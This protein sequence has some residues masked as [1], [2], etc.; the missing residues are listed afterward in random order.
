MIQDQQR[1]GYSVKTKSN[2]WRARSLLE[3]PWLFFAWLN[4]ALEPGDA[5]C[6]TPGGKNRTASLGNETVKA[7]LSEAQAG[8]M[9][10]LDFE[11][12][13]GLLRPNEASDA[14]TMRGRLWH[15]YMK[16]DANARMGAVTMGEY[17]SSFYKNGWISSETARRYTERCISVLIRSKTAGSRLA[18]AEL[19]ARHFL[20]KR[21]KLDSRAIGWIIRD[22]KSKSAD[23]N[24]YLEWL[25]ELPCR[26][27][28]VESFG[29]FLSHSAGKSDEL[30]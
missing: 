28:G 24:E 26:I 4:R 5:D 16:P 12:Q 3:K 2:A 13:A 9:R 17:L 6:E 11:R 14:G 23:E 15:H 8:G 18:G 1:S 20:Q 7:L 30:S 29:T 19:F 22:A 25:E 10:Q 27:L 21:Y